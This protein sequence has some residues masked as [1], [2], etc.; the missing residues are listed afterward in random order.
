MTT[1]DT[2]PVRAVLPAYR[3]ALGKGNQIILSAAPGAGKTTLIPPETAA[4]FPGGI[5]LIEPRRV[6][7]RAAA[8]RI[9]E[10][11]G[12]SVGGFSGFAVRGEV[13]R[14]KETRILAVTP[15]ILIREFQLD[16][17]LEGVSAVVFPELCI[18]GASCGD[19]FRQ[20]ILLDAAQKAVKFLLKE[21][22]GL[23]V[24]FVVGIP[25]RARS[26][27]LYAVALCIRAGMRIASSSTPSILNRT[28]TESAAG[29]RCTSE[30]WE[31][32]PARRMRSTRRRL[33][34]WPPFAI[35]Q[36]ARTS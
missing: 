9:A 13:R 11:T 17:S 18:T 4:C 27:V 7:A 36:Y 34:L 5:R 24:T 21:T 19:L 15:G 1:P 10:L 28:R 22:A 12:T 31:R 26:G 35:M 25:E 8:C 32:S 14:G 3:A 20:N 30:A 29:S 33:I 16:P 6:A 23:P 2:L